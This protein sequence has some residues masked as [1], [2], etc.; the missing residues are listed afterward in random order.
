MTIIRRVVSAAR[1]TVDTFFDTL[2]TELTNAVDTILRKSSSYA[3]RRK[4]DRDNFRPIDRLRPQIWRPSCWSARVRRRILARTGVPVQVGEDPRRL[5]VGARP[6]DRIHRPGGRAASDGRRGDRRPRPPGDAGPGQHAPPHI[7]VAHPRHPEG[8]GG[9]AVLVVEWY[10]LWAGLRRR[11]CA[12]RRSWRWPSCCWPAAPPAAT[13]V[14]LPEWRAAG[15][16]HRSV[17][18]DRLVVGFPQLG[19]P[20]FGRGATGRLGSSGRT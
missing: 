9:G 13:S 17:T 5:G 3:G 19:R 4:G 16:H 1:P 18:R 10:P 8:A 15:R 2:S 12:S 11:W 20:P 14:Y 6:P 7:P